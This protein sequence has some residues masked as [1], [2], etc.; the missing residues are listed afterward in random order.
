VI[1]VVYRA[2]AL[3]DLE[4]IASYIVEFEPDAAERVVRKIRDTIRNVLANHPYA[5]RANPDLGAR[6]FSVVGLPY[7]IIYC[8]SETTLD[9]VGVFHTRR[10]PKSKP[11]A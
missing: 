6:E 1:E 10:D 11:T 4:D 7:V 5:G 8:V 2:S 3:A 9:V